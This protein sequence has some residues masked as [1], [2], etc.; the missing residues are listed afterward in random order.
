MFI[1]SP[2]MSLIVLVVGPIAVLGIAGLVRRV[3]GVARQQFTSQSNLIAAM[4]E[5]AHGIRIVKAFNLEEPMR[6]RMAQSIDEVRSRADRIVR[7]GA[8]SSPLMEV[9]GGFAIA[10]IVL[11]AGYQVIYNDVQPGAL[12]S[13]IAAMALAYEPAKRL[14][15]MQLEIEAG[16]VGVRL[17]YELLDTP[18]SIA[19]N[20]NGPALTVTKGTVTFDKVD[21]SYEPTR[22]ALP[23]LR[24]HRAGREHDG[25]RRPV[26]ARARAPSFR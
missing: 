13:F 16:L 24:P 22:A 6:Q 14:A 17:M 19:P 2:L 15:R 11:W 21:F 12:M 1:Q 8:R 26:R 25:A 3:R 10:M 5:T 18:P 7:I 23:W 9:I 4:Q 20:P